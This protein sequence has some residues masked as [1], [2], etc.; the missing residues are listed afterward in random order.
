MAAFSGVLL[1][2]AILDPPMS[3][4]GQT[5]G[6]HSSRPGV[7]PMQR[8][9]GHMRGQWLKGG[10]GAVM[11]TSLEVDNASVWPFCMIRIVF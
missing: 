11:G 10:G 8:L 9:A 2:L 1:H 3:G 6:W 7:A 5:L 4:F